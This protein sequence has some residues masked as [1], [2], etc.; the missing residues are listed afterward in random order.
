M[1]V[2]ADIFIPEEVAQGQLSV[3]L[4]SKGEI[5]GSQAIL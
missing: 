4:G 2:I 1:F 3:G 5:F